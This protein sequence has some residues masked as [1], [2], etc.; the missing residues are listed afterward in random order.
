M[1]GTGMRVFFNALAAVGATASFPRDFPDAGAGAAVLILCWAGAVFC[2]A[3]AKTRKTFSTLAAAV[4][5]W[6]AAVFAAAYMTSCPFAS[7]RLFCTVA[8]GAVCVA[9]VFENRKKAER[10]F[11]FAAGFGAAAGVAAAFFVPYP[12]F[13]LAGLLCRPAQEGRTAMDGW[14]DVALPL[15]VLTG[16]FLCLGV[17]GHSGNF[18]VRAAESAALVM[19]G[20]FPVAAGKS[21]VRLMLTTAVVVLFGCYVFSAENPQSVFNSIF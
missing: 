18:S 12:A 8:V 19:A 10:A 21:G 9:N 2:A 1:T 20:A 17:A 7:F 5:P 11:W 6:A 13:I 3:S 14:I 15:F 16:A 4:Q